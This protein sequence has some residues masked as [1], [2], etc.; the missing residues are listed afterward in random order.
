MHEGPSQKSLKERGHPEEVLQTLLI[1]CLIGNT[2]SLHLAYE[3]VEC[4]KEM[5][6]TA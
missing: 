4:V 3:A 2:S 1:A 5:G 6:E